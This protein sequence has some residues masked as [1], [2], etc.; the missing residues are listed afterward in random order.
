MKH[1]LKLYK[2][3]EEQ[4]HSEFNAIYSEILRYELL[5][6][7][8][9]EEYLINNGRTLASLR[10]IIID[11]MMLFRKFSWEADKPLKDWTI[12]D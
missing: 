5:A 11:K 6:K 2:I 8:E 4:W 10:A 1:E 12:G 9:L 7:D 3:T